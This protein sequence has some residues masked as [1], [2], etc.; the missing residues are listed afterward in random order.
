MP[1]SG[2]TAYVMAALLFVLPATAGAASFDDA[3]KAYSEKDYKTTM[4]IYKTLAEQGNPRAQN[5]LA[6]MYDT[7]TGVNQD[8]KQAAEWYTKAAKQDHHADQ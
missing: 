6:N 8:L 1:L 4:Q 5:N 2:W 3:L 7:G